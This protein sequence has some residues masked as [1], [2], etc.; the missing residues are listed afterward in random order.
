M[1]VDVA[2]VVGRALEICNFGRADPLHGHCLLF[3]RIVRS[4]ARRVT[5]HANSIS[6]WCKCAARR[7]QGQHSCRLTMTAEI[8]S[9]LT[10]F[11]IAISH[12]GAFCIPFPG[13]R[14]YKRMVGACIYESRA[15]GMYALPNLGVPESSDVSPSVTISDLQP[16]L[17]PS[18]S[19]AIYFPATHSF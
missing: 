2:E 19:S 5:A 1:N 9:R 6:S 17:C 16:K 14:R 11:H 13:S 4:Q 8:S 10:G 15:E 3:E 18:L 12:I 7:G